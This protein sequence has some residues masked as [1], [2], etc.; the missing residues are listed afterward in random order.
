MSSE[1]T[2]EIKK[3]AQGS[4]EG[5]NP[6]GRLFAEQHTRLVIQPEKKI[7]LIKQL[8]QWK[9][10]LEDAYQAFKIFS[11]TDLTFSR[12]AEWMLDNYFLVEEAFYE[13]EE[14]LPNR[15]INQ[16]P[17]I[18]ETNLEGHPRIFALAREL[19]RSKLGQPSRGKRLRPSPARRAS[20]C[21]TRK[22]AIAA[23]ISGRSPKG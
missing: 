19:V 14:D 6:P 2:Q 16:L 1:P 8:D 17:K 18:K 20:G 13:I 5:S 21:A 10:M 4:N 11:E 12:S 9:S 7:L 15:Y 23:T 22:G 3:D